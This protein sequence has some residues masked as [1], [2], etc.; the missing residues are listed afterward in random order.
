MGKHECGSRVDCLSDCHD[1][2]RPAAVDIPAAVLFV[3]VEA[4]GFR[5]QGIGLTQQFT[6]ALPYVLALLVLI[7]TI[8]DR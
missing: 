2:W 6:E 3:L 7:N 8:S 1:V 4:V 5:M